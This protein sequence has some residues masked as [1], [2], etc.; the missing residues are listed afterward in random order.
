M[1]AEEAITKPISSVLGDAGNSTAKLEAPIPLG[2][3]TPEN[4][5]WEQ[6]VHHTFNI[7]ED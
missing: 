7:T 6:P 4:G 3:D 1:S 2:L 5:Y